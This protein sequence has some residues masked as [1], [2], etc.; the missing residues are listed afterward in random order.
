MIDLAHNGNTVLK[1]VIYPIIRLSNNKEW[2]SNGKMKK[3]GR[4]VLFTNDFILLL[5]LVAYMVTDLDRFWIERPCHPAWVIVFYHRHVRNWQE[6]CN[7]LIDNK[8]PPLKSAGYIVRLFQVQE[9]SYSPACLYRM[10]SSG[11]GSPARKH[12]LLYIPVTTPCDGFF[13]YQ[14]VTAVGK[15]A[16]GLTAVFLRRG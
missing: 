16:G 10:F 9:V 1:S 12:D 2:H 6:P 15:A 8:N 14:R 7:S 5:W 3:R 4:S 11:S 13:I